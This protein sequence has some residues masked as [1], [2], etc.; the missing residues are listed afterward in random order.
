[1]RRDV[2]TGLDTSR[3]SSAISYTA[4]QWLDVEASFGTNRA[5]PDS[6][7]SGVFAAIHSAVSAI[8]P[9]VVHWDATL[10]TAT[11]K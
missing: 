5:L 9:I 7:R 2:F 3:D 6:R 1:M 8:E 10:V 11:R 4:D